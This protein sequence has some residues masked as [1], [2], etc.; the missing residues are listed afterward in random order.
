[1]SDETEAA[2]KRAAHAEKMLREAEA[3]VAQLEA[4]RDSLHE[5]LEDMIQ[6][7]NE[8]LLRADRAEATVAQL[9]GVLKMVHDQMLGD[10]WTGPTWNEVVD[11]VKAAL[12]EPVVAPAP[13]E[14]EWATDLKCVGCGSK[15]WLSGK[16]SDCEA[17]R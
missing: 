7:R 10:L 9:R 3:R 13:A 17:D 11:A 15:L 1:M 6:A 12:A 2:W 8:Q 14:T 5:D 16:C 4:E